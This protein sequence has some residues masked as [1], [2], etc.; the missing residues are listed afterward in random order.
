MPGVGIEMHEVHT[1]SC[2][3]SLEAL[4]TEDAT[5]SFELRVLN[6]LDALTPLH[7]LMLLVFNALDL[8]HP[9]STAGSTTNCNLA[10]LFRIFPR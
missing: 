7:E 6:E 9:V 4:R 1:V 5:G 8:T 2:L 10:K 3:Y